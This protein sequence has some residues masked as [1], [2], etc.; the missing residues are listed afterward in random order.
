VNDC[1]SRSDLT[2]GGFGL[3]RGTFDDWSPL[4][5]EGRSAVDLSK[6]VLVKGDQLVVDRKPVSG[7]TLPGRC[8]LFAVDQMV[9]LLDVQEGSL[10]ERL[11]IEIWISLVA[12]P[13]RTLY[14]D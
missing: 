2:R 10:R 3:T 1:Q 13:T 6:H 8:P 11:P 9:R 14:L 12:V 5:G 4:R 7:V